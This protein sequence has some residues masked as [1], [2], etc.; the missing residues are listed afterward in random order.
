METVTDDELFLEA[1]DVLKQTSKEDIL[2]AIE[3]LDQTTTWAIFNQL[4]QQEK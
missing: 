4:L 3:A 2:K 1:Q